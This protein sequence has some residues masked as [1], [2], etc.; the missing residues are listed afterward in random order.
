M[1]ASDWWRR[2]LSSSLVSHFNVLNSMI[3]FGIQPL[4]HLFFLCTHVIFL[5]LVPCH[6]SAR[7]MMRAWTHRFNVKPMR[8]LTPTLVLTCSRALPPLLKSGR[9]TFNSLDSHVVVTHWRVK[10]QY[11]VSLAQIN[12]LH[13]TSLRQY[14]QSF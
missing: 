3:L 11:F 1:K 2:V 8:K 14:D 9:P 10:S 13:L 12:H 5:T 7:L 4:L 6:F